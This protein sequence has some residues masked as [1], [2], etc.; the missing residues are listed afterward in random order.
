[1]KKYLTGPWLVFVAALLWAIDAPFRKHLT[2]DI[3]STMIVF[4]GHATIVVLILIFYHKYFREFRQLGIREWLGVAFV[5]IG[6]SALATIFFTQ[7]FIYINPSV[8]ILLQKVQPFIAILL[9][10]WILKENLSKQFWVWALVGIFGAYLITFPELKISGL[11]FDGSSKG[12]VFA[13]L[14]AFFWGGSTVFGRHVL[15]KISFQAMTAVRF[16]VATVFLLLLNLY[17]GKMSEFSQIT[18]LDWLYIFMIALVTGF[19]PLIIY[20]RGLKYTKASVATIAELS[21]PFSAVIVNWIFIPDS[22]LSEVQVIG[23]AILLFAIWGLSKVN[24]NDLE[25]TII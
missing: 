10:V 24:K 7:S 4:L 9:A 23:G 18:N 16:L 14:A 1:M 11:S 3:S 21:F 8:P 20:Y 25:E 13:L 17:M 19:I 2:E 12:I 15:R 22:N 5:A 6:G